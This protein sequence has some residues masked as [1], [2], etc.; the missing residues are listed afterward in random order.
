MAAPFTVKGAAG[1]ELGE[2]TDGGSLVVP[3]YIELVDQSSAPAAPRSGRL[4]LY[5][6]GGQL[7]QVDADGGSQ[8]LAG[9]V[10]TSAVGTIAGTTSAGA[11]P[12][13]TITDCTDQRGNFL[14]NP[15]TGGGAQAAGKV[16]VVRFARAYST[17]PGAVL[18]TMANETD[19]TA[20]IVVAVLALATTGFDIYVGTA[21][22]TAKA[23]RICYQV[24]P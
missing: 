23:Y 15:V 3:G 16:A 17:A 19:S 1:Q 10:G 7:A 18:I 21:L 22:T 24:I 4:R 8:L 12:T 6:S 20:T 9:A 14:L 11:S 2:W 13:V 5:S